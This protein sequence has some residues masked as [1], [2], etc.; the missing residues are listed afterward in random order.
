MATS[1][2][3]NSV[4]MSDTNQWWQT[5]ENDSVATKRELWEPLAERVDGF[6]LDPASGCEPTPIATDRYTPKDDGLL[7]PWYGTVWLNPPFSEKTQWYKKL[8]DE[9]WNGDIERAVA[10]ATVDPSA[11]WFHE[12][13]STA[14]V[15]CFLDG[16]DWYLGQGDSPTFSTQVGVWNPTDDV[17]EYLHTIGTVVEPKDDGKQTTLL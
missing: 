3:R 12:W 17:V 14:D 7:Q 10:L 13:F 15:L 8:V 1:A 9:Y 16:R 6:D 5:E 4:R 2:W 11:D